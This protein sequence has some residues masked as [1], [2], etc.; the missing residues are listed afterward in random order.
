MQI[1]RTRPTRAAL[2]V[3]L[4]LLAV[5]CGSSQGGA[6]AQGSEINVTERDFGI[7]APKVVQAGS[8][9]LHVENQ[10]PD[11][12]EL[13]IVRAQSLSLPLRS[14]GLTVNEEGLQPQTVGVLE[15]GQPHD[16]REL[17]LRLKPGRY[18]LFCNMSGHYMGGMHTMLVVR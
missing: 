1:A 17:D 12:H 18:V 2:G 7:S 13:V 5:G 11:S 16:V 4:P 9:V 15:G 14:D 3:L 10:G 8:V 6:R